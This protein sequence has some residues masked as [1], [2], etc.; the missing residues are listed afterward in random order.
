MV[1]FLDVRA[2]PCTHPSAYVQW[3][4]Q[5][6]IEHAPASC[7]ERTVVVFV[8]VLHYTPSATPGW[9]GRVS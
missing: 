1:V 7:H 4:R 9:T 3:I 5:V 8:T 2:A 6:L